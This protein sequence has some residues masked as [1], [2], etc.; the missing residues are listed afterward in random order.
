MIIGE[1]ITDGQTR[2]N[3]KHLVLTEMVKW[4]TQDLLAPW[5][6]LI[7]DDGLE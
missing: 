3:S 5:P 4:K 2:V 1:E 7:T 6:H